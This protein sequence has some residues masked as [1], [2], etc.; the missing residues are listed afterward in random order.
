MTKVEQ[1][2][3]VVRAFAEKWNGKGG[4]MRNRILLLLILYPFSSII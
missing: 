1:Q 3:M 2:E 4:V